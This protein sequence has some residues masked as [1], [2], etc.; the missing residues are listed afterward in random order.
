[1]LAA[2]ILL[3][4]LGIIGLAV[5]GLNGYIGAHTLDASFDFYEDKRRMMKLCLLVGTVLVIAGAVCFILR[6]KA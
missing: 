2:G 4:V 3:L 5:G 1:M 6:K